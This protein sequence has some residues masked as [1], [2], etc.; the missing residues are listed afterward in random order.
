MDVNNKKEVTDT[1]KCPIGQY[2]FEHFQPAQPD[3][4]HNSSN[5]LMS[6]IWNKVFN[7]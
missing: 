4:F 7:C 3:N 2:F 5:N 1:N 6:N